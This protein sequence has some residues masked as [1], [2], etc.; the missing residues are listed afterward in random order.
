MDDLSVEEMLE[1][2][3]KDETQDSSADVDSG[4]KSASSGS[5]QNDQP[6]IE[7]LLDLSKHGKHMVEYKAN[8]K[9]VREP[10][11]QAL[12][13]SSQGYN[14]AQLI[15]EFGQ[16][17]PGY[18]KQIDELTGKVTTLSKWE[19]YDKYARENPQWGE[20]VSRLWEEKGRYSDPNLDPEDPVA[21]RIA[22]M[23]KRLESVSNQYGEK[24][25]KFESKL[26]EE[27]SAKVEAEFDTHMESTK[28][29]FAMFDFDKKD[30]SGK[31]VTT[32]VLEHMVANKI[33]NFNT[34]FLDLYHDQ[35]IESREQAILEKQAKQTQKRTKEG[36]IAKSATPSGYANGKI[37]NVRSTGWNELAELAKKELGV[38]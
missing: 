20:H 4:S 34:A 14:Y 31:N 17:E 3:S 35:I 19:Q 28:T 13:R 1:S 22:D 25:S 30:E 23:E 6:T 37:S 8:G 11:E 7:E 36:F 29:K 2:V 21:K 16:K 26:S 10:L 27:E 15:N 5:K 24:I 9:M 33:P 12:Q 32:Y 18:K 38:G